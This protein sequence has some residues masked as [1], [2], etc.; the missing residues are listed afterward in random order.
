MN[1]ESNPNPSGPEPGLP[2]KIPSAGEAAK[3][4]NQF[5]PMTKA[6]GLVSALEAVLRYPKQVIFQLHMGAHAKLS[7]CLLAI[8]M[9]GVIGY[10]GL[11]GAFS[12]G[13]QLWAA[14]AKLAAGLIFSGL[15]CLPSLYIFASL[16]GI[17]VRAG[18]IAGLLCA[19]I[20]LTAVLLIG[21]V[22]VAW[23][24][25]ASTY[26][27]NFVGGL[28]LIVWIIAVWF[29][30]RLLFGGLDYA[31]SSRLGHLRVWGLIFV[32]VCL[33][34]TATLRPIVGTADTL[35]PAERKFF[36]VHWWECLRLQERMTNHGR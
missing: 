10:G 14:P 8:G 6:V 30:L 33:Q 5:K 20:A 34:M 11:V 25:T 7:F 4:G 19:A 27:V 18:A 22:P 13:T 12:G 31:K 23:L 28:H 3:V 15:I 24:F 36:V 9:A 1:I 26:S 32:L 2:P 17:E 16:N 35:L 21:F 29:G